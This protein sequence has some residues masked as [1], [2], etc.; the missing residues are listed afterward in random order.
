MRCRKMGVFCLIFL[1]LVLAITVSRKHKTI[2]KRSYFIVN[3]TKAR[4]CRYPQYESSIFWVSPWLFQKIIEMILNSESEECFNEGN[5]G[6]YRGV[7]DTTVNGRTCQK[8]T[9]QSPYS[10]SYTP[11]KYPKYAGTCRWLIIRY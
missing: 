5:T 2:L 3:K 11:T 8:W 10:H 4:L 6:S 1:C 9:S 7:M